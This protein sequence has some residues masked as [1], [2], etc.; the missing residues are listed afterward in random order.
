LELSRKFSPHVH[1]F[2]HGCVAIF[3]P[4][5]IECCCKSPKIVQSDMLRYGVE[6]K[7]AYFIYGSSLSQLIAT[8]ALKKRFLQY[9]N[10]VFRWKRRS[11]QTSSDFPP[12]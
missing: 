7:Q 4:L 6:E 10:A 8:L 3:F 9:E 12:G 5:G 1:E 11:R 2:E